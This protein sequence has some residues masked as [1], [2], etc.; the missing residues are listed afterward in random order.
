MHRS[1]LPRAYL[2][3]LKPIEVE[4]PID[5]YVHRPLG[6]GIARLCFPTRITPNQLTAGA[7]ACGVAAGIVL[8]V[9]FPGHLPI[10][11]LCVLLATIFDCADGMLARM[12]RSSSLLGRM[13]DGVADSV[14]VAAVVAGSLVV[15]ASLYAPPWWQ[16]AAAIAVA[17]AAIV[18][19][20]HHTAGYDHYKNVYLR[21]TQPEAG[22]G[23]DLAQ[24]LERHEAEKRRRPGPIGRAAWAVYLGYLR[25]QRAWIA[26]FDPHTA[27]D[28]GQLPPFDARRAAIYRA[29]AGGAMRLWR[30]LFGTGSLMFGLTVF[31]AIGRPDLLLLLR[32]VVLNGILHLYLKPAQRRASRAAFEEMGLAPRARAGAAAG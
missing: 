6:Y 24:A 19:S 17:A 3:A 16:A 29:H 1:P 20:A 22:E 4:E 15:L 25:R 13:L 32:L 14:T 8:A 12:R 30:G 21:L 7:I 27:P 9:P 2:S 26:R 10:G 18:T 11:A 23:E 28:V 31:S 5:V